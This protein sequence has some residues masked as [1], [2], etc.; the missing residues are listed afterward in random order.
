MR[1]FHRTIAT[2]T[3]ETTSAKNGGVRVAFKEQRMLR[4]FDNMNE[5][6]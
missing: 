3:I 1:H 6:L 2:T 4:A 5:A